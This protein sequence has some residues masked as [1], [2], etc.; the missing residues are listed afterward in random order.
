MSMPTK[1]DLLK[2][3]TGEQR[4]SFRIND[5]LPVIIRKIEDDECFSVGMHR[6]MLLALDLDLQTI[7]EAHGER[8]KWPALNGGL[9]G[10]RCHDST[11]VSR[12][13]VFNAAGLTS[14]SSAGRDHVLDPS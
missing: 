7:R 9:D 13:E 3:A 14:V 12:S 6:H 1:S 10:F 4:E 11:L 2:P 8:A 5:A